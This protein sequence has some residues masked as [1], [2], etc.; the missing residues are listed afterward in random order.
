MKHEFN[1][2]SL[3]LTALSSLDLVSTDGGDTVNTSYHNGESQLDLNNIAALG[4]GIWNFTA[5][6]F[7]GLTGR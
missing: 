7:D 6:L 1:L 4:A 5:G 2:E 3:C